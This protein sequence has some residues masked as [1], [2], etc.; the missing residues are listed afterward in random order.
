MAYRTR[1]SGRPGPAAGEP[2]SE[3]R[4]DRPATAANLSAGKSAPKIDFAGKVAVVTGGAMGIG[5]ATAEL[6]CE[7]GARVAIL[8]R[9]AEHGRDL[10]GRLVACGYAAS[11]HSCDVGDPVSTR[12]AFEAAAQQ[13]GAMQVLVHSAGI[14]RYG[15]VLSTSDEVWHETLRVHVDGCFHAVRCAI[16]HLIAAGGGSIVIVGSVQ[17]VAAVAGSAAYVTAKHALLGLTRSIA[18]DFASRH[19]RANCVMPGAV[20]TPMLRASLEMAPDPEGVLEGC[21]RAHPVGR[22]GLPEEVARAIAFLAS[23]W[24]SFITGAALAVDGG[25][26]VPVGGMGFQEGGMGSIAKR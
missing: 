3:R 15:D 22:I 1:A 17:T 6:L 4:Q 12:A 24:A 13:H 8:D 21:R 16:P 5:A 11:F 14:Q 10:A 18:L 25:M 2:V 23:D 26:L 7:L 9:D 19:V 20:D